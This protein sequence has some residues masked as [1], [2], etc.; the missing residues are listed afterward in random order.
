V[1]S[2]KSQFSYVIIPKLSEHAYLRSISTNQTTFPFLA[3]K[4]NVFM[5]DTFV[6]NSEL[7]NTNPGEELTLYLGADSTIVV[8]YK[9]SLFRETKGIISKTS[10]TRYLHEISVKNSKKKEIQCIIFDQLPKSQD[11]DIKVSVIKPK[12]EEK[13]GDGVCTLNNMHNVKW[14]K[15]IKGGESYSIAFEFTVEHPSAKNIRFT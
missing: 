14:Q 12:I 15:A 10:K 6:T 8:Q 5:G 2:L 11:S 9:E 4:A 1:I 13:E 3:G 7:K